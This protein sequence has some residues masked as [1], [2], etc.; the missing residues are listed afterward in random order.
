[1]KKY[2]YAELR[3]LYINFFQDK[4]HQKLSSFPLVPKDD[5]SLLLINAGM[6]P[7]KKY[8]T[9]AAKPPS[10][11]ITT[12]QKCIRTGDIDS[13]GRTARHCT[14]FEM[15]GNFSFGDYFKK[16]AI[17]YA[18]EFLT[19]VI[20]IP[21]EKLYVSVYI[22]DNEAFDCW[23]NNTGIT[24]DRIFKM[25]KDENFWEI[26]VGPCGPCSEIFYSFTDEKIENKEQFIEFQES[27]KIFEI[28]N[29]VFTQFN[30]N[31]NGEYET[32]KNK[33]IDTGMGLERLAL[34]TQNVDN[35]FD[36]DIFVKIIDK[37]R[38][39][40]NV[41]NIS[42]EVNYSLK[43]IADHSR[44]ITFLVC[45]G[46]TP[47]NEGRGYVLR[48]LI[49][50][51]VRHAKL[52]GI[53]SK[54]INDI[55]NVVIDE[56]KCAYP[57]LE[58][59]KEYIRNIV[60]VEEDNFSKTLNK[61]M[62][63]LLNSYVKELET[64]NSNVLSGDKVFKLYD[65]Y[66]FP[67]ELTQE[68]LKERN[69][70][71]DID[72][73]N[74]EMKNQQK[75]AR[76]SRKSD[77]YLGNELGVL[78]STKNYETEFVGYE[79]LKIKSKIMDMIFENSF[80]DEMKSGETGFIIFDKTPFYP[81]M[82]G[83]IGD[84]GYIKSSDGYGKV[85]TTKKNL[86]GQIYHV[87]EVV[88]G[89]ICG[90]TRDIELVVDE[91][92][93]RSICRNHTAT[94][95][96]QKALKM[97]L[98]DHVKQSGSYLDDQK[99]RFDFTHF[100]ALT[101]NELEEVEKIVNECIYNQV[102]VKTEIMDI[103]S[104]QEVGAIALFDEKYEDKVR[105][106]FVGDF[107]IEFCGGTHVSNTGFIGNFVILNETSVSSGVRRIEATTGSNVFNLFKESRS[108]LNNISHQVKATSQ[109]DIL[110]KVENLIVDIKNKNLEISNLKS[111]MANAKLKVLDHIIKNSKIKNGIK[112]ITNVFDELD[113]NQLRDACTM[114]R[115]KLDCGI[116]M[117]A[118]VVNDRANVVCM[119]NKN[120]VD[121]GIDCGKI[122]REALKFAEGSGGGRKD[123]AQGSVT[124]IS[125]I[126]DAFEKVYEII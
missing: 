88:E 114:V 39:L 119:A 2:T 15:L 10:K 106:L 5:E 53:E 100:K 95:L 123:M 86:Q 27:G 87:V 1:M 32:L 121:Q 23:I 16:E 73:F 41:K 82:G 12:Y 56:Y 55:S 72:G 116:V 25:G 61:G 7:L 89:K 76:E 48:R 62:D 45:D 96:L 84:T 110:N 98:G 107:S 24:K 78:N 124:N 79:K 66:G 47:S 8:F 109:I 75:K 46:V 103:K 74:S 99:L 77:N 69:I 93:R 34:I 112:V 22:E 104:A 91:S 31:E 113:V 63:I 90:K 51:S 26:G 108:V 9:G 17:D 35:V 71:V 57:E 33:N 50:R 60:E 67:L 92:R 80:V 13:V 59:R 102:N 20:E 29:L 97:V 65:T 19:K 21:L 122:I 36:T 115:D 83:Q 120:A 125:K 70:S 44:S 117:F 42:Q 118:S 4:S 14:F 58:E 43:V 85:L 52:I 111:K 101:K 18:W 37:I 3:E 30:K 38:K 94:H 126:G 105:V 81:E 49:R 54:F 28:W 64:L 40:S 68:I 6:A 11:R